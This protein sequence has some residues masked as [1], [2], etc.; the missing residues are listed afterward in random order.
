MTSISYYYHLYNLLTNQYT[1]Y[2]RDYVVR[3]RF[4]DDAMGE[5][6]LSDRLYGPVFQPLKT[7][8]TSRPLKWI[9]NY[10]PLFGLTGPISR[11]SSWMTE[12]A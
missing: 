5:V 7:R 4:D 2:V 9:R 8:N 12:P 3:L 11:P 6:D 10:T 1:R